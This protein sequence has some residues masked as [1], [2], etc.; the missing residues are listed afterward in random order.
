MSQTGI[1]KPYTSFIIKFEFHRV[2][3]RYIGRYII[4]IELG[5]NHIFW[6]EAFLGKL[7]RPLN[8]FLA[9]CYE[10]VGILLTMKP[11]QSLRISAVQ[12]AFRVEK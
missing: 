1:G 12:C 4:N 3:G 2:F 5:I 8:T 10:C 11:S 9:D 7:K 6:G